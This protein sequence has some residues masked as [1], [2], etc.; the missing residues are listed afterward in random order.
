VAVTHPGK[1][2]KAVKGKA[3]DTRVANKEAKK[4]GAKLAAADS[5]KAPSKV[6]KA[7]TGDKAKTAAAKPAAPAQSIKVAKSGN[8][9]RG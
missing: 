1:P 6:A 2:E 4:G 3:A 9:R 5:A 8:G 7:A